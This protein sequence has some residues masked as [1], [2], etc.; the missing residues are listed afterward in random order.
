[1]EEQ[2]RTNL[3]VVYGTA[4]CP[5]CRRAKRFLD[6][7]AVAYL[8]VDIENDIQAAAYI[9][10]LNHGRRVIPTIVFPDGTVLFE[11]SNRE[12]GAKLGLQAIAA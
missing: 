9:L 10:Q 7:H 1:M 5:D 2:R 6:N 4:W 3:I 12:L 11:P 8:N